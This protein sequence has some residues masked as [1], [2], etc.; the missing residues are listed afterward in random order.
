[1]T[2][3]ERLILFMIGATLL[4]ILLTAAIFIGLLV[5]YSLT[6]GQML[7]L[8]SVG[9]V[10][11]IAFV[12]AIVASSLIYKKVLVALRKKIDFEATFGKIK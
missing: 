11:A 9:I 2:K 10:V 12:L 3:R 5:L 4:N 1:M 6:L 7:K 8:P